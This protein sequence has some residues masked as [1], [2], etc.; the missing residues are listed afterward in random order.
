MDQGGLDDH[1]LPLALGEDPIELVDHDCPGSAGSKND[2]ALHDAETMA[3]K[4]WQIGPNGHMA[5]PFNQ[6]R[7]APWLLPIDRF[8][9]TRRWLRLLVDRLP[10]PG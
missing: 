3:P 10:W 8:A 1:D 2:Y 5:G 4:R 6:R 7:L 9:R